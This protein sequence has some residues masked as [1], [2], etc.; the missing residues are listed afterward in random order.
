MA[1]RKLSKKAQSYISAKIKKLIEEGYP[2]KQAIAIAYSYARKRGFK[3]R[4]KRK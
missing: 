1:K 2:Q 4:R 3:V